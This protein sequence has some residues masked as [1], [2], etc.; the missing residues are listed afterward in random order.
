M[1]LRP[2][3]IRLA[4][5]SEHQP[6][7][8]QARHE[9]DAARS[10]V[11]WP[12]HAGAQRMHAPLYSASPDTK[13]EIPKLL[14]V[15]PMAQ[16]CGLAKTVLAR[17][18]PAGLVEQALPPAAASES[19]RYEPRLWGHVFSTLSPGGVLPI[20][21]ENLN[22]QARELNPRASGLKTS[23]PNSSSKG[24]VPSCKWPLHQHASITA[25]VHLWIGLAMIVRGLCGRANTGLG[26]AQAD[27]PQHPHIMLGQ[28]SA[29]VASPAGT[30][31]MQS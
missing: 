10:L 12:A 27:L 4:I 3:P 22:P 1:R 15:N 14:W 18:L 11:Q 5:D 2:R 31:T 21:S 17:A 30:C 7:C 6:A 13:A 20:R 19:N 29:A 23:T 26:R 28:R 8:T 16:L 24:A 9:R 25:A